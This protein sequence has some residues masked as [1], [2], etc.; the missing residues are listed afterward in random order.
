MYTQEVTKL[1][2]TLVETGFQDTELISCQYLKPV[3][4][5]ANMK[6]WASLKKEEALALLGKIHHCSPLPLYPSSAI[7]LPQQ[8][9]AGAG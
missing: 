3:R 6:T 9:R 5:Q 4:F 8:T 7:F 1:V 2:R